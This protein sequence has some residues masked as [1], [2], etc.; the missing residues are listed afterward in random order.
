VPLKGTDESPRLFQE[1]STEAVSPGS[2]TPLPSDPAPE[3]ESTFRAK[4]ARMGVGVKV[5]VSVAVFV[6][7]GVGV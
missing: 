1:G 5:G 2:K 6:G 4:G 3:A 7:V